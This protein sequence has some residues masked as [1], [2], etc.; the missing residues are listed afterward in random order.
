MT[1]NGVGGALTGFSGAVRELCDCVYFLA[2]AREPKLVPTNASISGESQ[3]APASLA[4]S[5]RL[6]NESLSHMV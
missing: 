1:E 6:A 5:L 4:D 3:Q 2:L